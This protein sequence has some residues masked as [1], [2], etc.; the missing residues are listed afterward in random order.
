MRKRINSHFIRIF[1]IR[2]AFYYWI[3]CR[4]VPRSAWVSGKVP[5]P[6]ALKNASRAAFQPI[7]DDRLMARAPRCLDSY[8][9]SLFR[10]LTIL[11]A[12]SNGGSNLDAACPTTYSAGSLNFCKHER[13]NRSRRSR[14][15]SLW[16]VNSP[17]FEYPLLT[18]ALALLF[19][20]HLPSF[21]SMQLPCIT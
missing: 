2:F 21:P 4:E 5:M 17:A 9:D 11:H 14:H 20:R 13:L 3:L 15:W 18:S 16:W 7:G 8:S 1:R 19:A 12:F 10:L 6:H